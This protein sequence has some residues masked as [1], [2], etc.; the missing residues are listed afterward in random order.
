MTAFDFFVRLI[1]YC[2]AN[3][4][5]LQQAFVPSAW[6]V[7]SRR[8]TPV[9]LAAVLVSAAQAQAPQ[10]FR[11]SFSETPRLAQ[12]ESR[13]LFVRQ[14]FAVAEATPAAPAASAYWTEA[15]SAAASRLPRI[16][17]RNRVLA[18]VL[19]GLPGSEHILA[20]RS[21]GRVSVKPLV[22]LDDDRYGIRLR[23]RVGR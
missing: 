2:V 11:V 17:V 23:F 10:T 7:C 6:A 22:D 14:S 3:P 16:V 15:P 9:L 20:E 21:A 18:T 5:L 8:L 12:P 1:F 4:R 19:S 13:E